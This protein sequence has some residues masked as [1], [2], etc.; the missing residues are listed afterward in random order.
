MTGRRTIRMMVAGLAVAAA[1]L[2]TTGAAS[3]AS[4]TAQ[5]GDVCTVSA[6][7][8]EQQ[9]FDTFSEA[10]ES[11][12]GEQ[13]ADPG[14]DAGDRTAIARVVEAHDARAHAAYLNRVAATAPRLAASASLATASTPASASLSASSNLVLGAVWKNKNW[15]GGSKVLYAANGSGCYGTTYGFPHTSSFGMN[16]T[17]SSVTA[18]YNCATTL[19]K[20]AN[21][22]GTNRTYQVDTAYVGDTMNDEASSIVY[23]PK[24]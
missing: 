10:L 22:K 16:D 13:V 9:C 3:G 1:A 12:T 18:Y 15:T 21:Y 5:T 8:G 6:D 4:P 14:V 7:T 2:A 23:R 17:I 24:S 19:Y 20:D 11:I